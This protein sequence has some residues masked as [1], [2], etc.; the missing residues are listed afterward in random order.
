[1]GQHL[2]ARQQPLDQQLD[3]TAGRLLAEQPRLD[4]AGVVEDQQVRR[5]QQPKAARGTAGPP[6]AARGRRA[7]R[8]PLRSGV[9]C[10]AISSC[11]STKSKS[12]TV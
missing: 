1:V 4:D 2:V 11:G 10:C 7:S 3:R 12:S 5:R 6:A 8:E 9:G